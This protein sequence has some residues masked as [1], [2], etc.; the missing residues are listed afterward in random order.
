MRLYLDL[1]L[2]INRYFLFVSFLITG[3]LT[4][5]S[6]QIYLQLVPQPLLGNLF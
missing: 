5:Y 1:Q 3:S 4:P 6:H 2:D